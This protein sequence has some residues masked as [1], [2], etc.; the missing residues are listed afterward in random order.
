MPVSDTAR[1][2]RC[3]G[4]PA[5]ARVLLDDVQNTRM[6]SDTSDLGD[7]YGYDGAKRLVTVLR[8][9]P[10]AYISDSLY[11]N[12]TNTHFDD[13]VEYDYDQTGN[14]TTRRIDGSDD[15]VYAHNAVNEM[16]TQDGYTHLYY[17]NGTLKES[18]AIPASPL[19]E[20]K[21]NYADQLARYTDG[22]HAYLWHFDA[23]GRRIARENVGTG[24]AADTR[25]YYDGEH[26]IE[27][28]NWTGSV[29]NQTRL[30]VFG[31]TIDELLEYVRINVDPDE[32][33]YAH[34][35][36]LGSIMIMTDTSG[37]I[38]EG[39][40]YQEFGDGLET[41]DSSFA[42]T[43]SPASAIQQGTRYTGRDY[44]GVINMVGKPWYHYRARAYSADVGRFVQRDPLTFVDGS[45]LYYYV[46]NSPTNFSDPLGQDAWSS[47]CVDLCMDYYE[48]HW[49]LWYHT[50]KMCL[51][52]C[53]DLQKHVGHIPIWH[54][55]GG[56]PPIPKRSEPP[57]AMDK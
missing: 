11:D 27:V 20:L 51:A 10:T 14:R 36:K 47:G 21:Y 57:A 39:Y 49:M 37:A 45:N 43:A 13:K 16:T 6:S 29:E 28:V 17:D 15:A 40:R 4:G 3:P 9:V 32:E 26:G 8:G 1:R 53:K 54:V 50:K 44:M 23:L 24:G 30:S 35:D 22:S 42:H 25:T 19:H 12:I 7:Q 41:V 48:P 5:R 31:E 56:F 34:A 52:L 38:V 18:T 46:M 2:S 33:F 55:T